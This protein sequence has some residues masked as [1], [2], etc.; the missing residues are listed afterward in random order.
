MVTLAPGGEVIFT[1]DQHIWD[2]ADI[3]GDSMADLVSVRDQ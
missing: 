3:I 2:V 1:K